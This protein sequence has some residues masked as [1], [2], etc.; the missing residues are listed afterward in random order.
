MWPLPVSIGAIRTLAL[1]H[2]ALSAKSSRA[3]IFGESGEIYVAVFP[4]SLYLS[5]PRN[6]TDYWRHYTDREQ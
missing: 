2:M 1:K 3:D 6:A 4:N 5:R